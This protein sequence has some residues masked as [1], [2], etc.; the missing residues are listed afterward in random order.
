M[1][2]TLTEAEIELGRALS[3]SI[4]AQQRVL[5]AL[6]MTEQLYI[7][8][9]RRARNLGDDYIVRHWERGFEH[10]QQNS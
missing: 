6:V 5:T 4:E 9:L 3:A 2:T 8:Q 1:T 10:G 7:E